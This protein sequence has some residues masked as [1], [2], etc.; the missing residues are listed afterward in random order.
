MTVRLEKEILLRV[1]KG[2]SCVLVDGPIIYSCDDDT[3]AII[4]KN[5]LEMIPEIIGF[6]RAIA[7]EELSKFEMAAEAFRFVIGASSRYKLDDG[8]SLR[9]SRIID[10]E[11]RQNEIVQLEQAA[12]GE[13]KCRVCGCTEDDAC[14]GPCYW[15]ELDLCSACVGAS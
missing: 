11:L 3:E 5:C 9:A 12:A 1:T 13:R 10:N 14:A 6:A 8:E 4:I 15:V 2:K 7:S